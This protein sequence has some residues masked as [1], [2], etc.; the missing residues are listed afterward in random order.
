MNLFS[1]VGIIIV[2]VALVCYSIAIIS[3]QR[4]RIVSRKVL[5]FL[6]MG[7]VFDIT[8][9]TFMILGTSQGAFTLHGI[10]GY[11]SLAGMVADAI[12]IYQFHR[13]NS[14]GTLVSR[15]VHIYSLIAYL[16]WI[17]AYITGGLLVALRHS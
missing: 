14:P 7:V 3:E 5:S 9:T 17:A 6:I 16:W 12:I 15:P 13:K 2:Q 1:I 10:L 11:S 4:K 8:A